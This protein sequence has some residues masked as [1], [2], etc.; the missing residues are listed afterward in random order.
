MPWHAR[1]DIKHKRSVTGQARHVNYL[2]D[3]TCW[4]VDMGLKRTDIR[5]CW[6]KFIF[7]QLEDGVEFTVR[8]ENNL[9]ANVAL[10][11]MSR[12]RV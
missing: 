5:Q 3:L 1:A 7:N 9:T 10:S 8:I 12:V 11:G 4:G 2:S 6:L